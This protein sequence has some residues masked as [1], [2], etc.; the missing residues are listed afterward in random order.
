MKNNKSIII[1]QYGGFHG[2]HGAH[3]AHRAG[4]LQFFI[5]TIP[6]KHSIPKKYVL[7][8]KYTLS[9]PARC[10]KRL[11]TI[12]KLNAAK[13]ASEALSKSYS[14]AE[15]KQKFALIAASKINDETRI[16]HAYSAAQNR[17][18]DQCD[19]LGIQKIIDWGI[20]HPNYVNKLLAQE[21]EAWKLG[22]YTPAATHN[23]LDELKRAN[24]IIVPSAFVKRTFEENGFPTD[25]FLTIPYGV[26]C[27]AFFPIKKERENEYLNV[28]TPGFSTRKGTLYILQ[29]IE[30]LLQRDIKIRLFVLG[31]PEPALKD[32]AKRY[33][34]A[35]YR[36]TSIP[37]SKITEFYA[38]MDVFVLPSL[39]EGMARAVLEAMAC[40]LPC[41]IT[42]NCGY[43]GIIK[44]KDNGLIVPLKNQKAIEKE[45]LELY[46]NKDVRNIMGQNALKT[47]QKYPWKNYEDQ[48]QSLYETMMES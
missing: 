14:I 9:L 24:K 46:Q 23:I 5:T 20:A 18:W 26:D 44:H 4:R 16:F 47:A 45:L 43:D 37:H 42:P 3:A 31:E 11:H 15:N 13:S 29:A 41:I 21:Y 12:M 40:G 2:E 19:T 30:S 48:L 8:L 7:N 6:L 25:N 39:A 10:I 1:S 32:I 27:E 22:T 38:D 28:V 33:E 35:I 34:H 36:N 17:C